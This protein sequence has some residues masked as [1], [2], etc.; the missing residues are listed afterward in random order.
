AVWA[1]SAAAHARKAAADAVLDAD[2]SAPAIEAATKA[3]AAASNATDIAVQAGHVKQAIESANQAIS[4]AYAAAED[5]ELAAIANED[6]A[7]FATEAGAEASEAV[8]QARLARA[9][10]VR[11]QRAAQAAER[12]LQVALA[13]TIAARDAALRAA[14]NAQAAAQAALHAAEHAGQAAE[15]ASLATEH[16]NAATV[17][18][19]AAVDAAAQAGT[20]FDAAR[21]ADAERLA[22]MRDEGLEGAQAANELYEAQQRQADFD[23]EQATKRDQQ[24][25]QLIAL[26]QN[27]ATPT[28]EAVAAARQV[29]L[30]LAQGQGVYT[31]QAAL[32]SLA[33]PDDQALEFVRTGLAAAEARDDRH[34][35]MNI[36][37]TDNAALAAAARTALAG[38]DAQVRTFL[39]TQNYPGRYTQDRVKVN[40]L[41]AAASAAGDVVLAQAA[42]AA[43]NAE[44]LQALREFLDTG[45]YTAAATGQRVRVNQ[46]AAAGG[47]EVKAAA[48]IALDGPPVLLAEFLGTGQYTAAERDYESMAH[49]STVGGM[50][51]NI[52]QIATTA[53]QNSQLAHSVAA[54]ARDD[55]QQA[56]AYAMQAAASAEQA[57]AYAIQ[58]QAYVAEA[59]QAVDKA[60]AA[61]A[62]ARS[63]ATRASTSARSAIRSAGWALLSHQAAVQSAI[64]AHDAA[65]FARA[66]AL[67]TG[68][69]A[70]DAAK[71]AFDAHISLRNVSI[72][73]CHHD[74]V[75]TPFD[76]L[77]ELWGQPD[78][79]FGRNCV[80]NNIPNPADP[81][82]FVKRIYGNAALCKVYPEGGQ[83]Y[84]NCVNST[85]DPAFGAMMPMTY[86]AEALKSLTATFATVG[87]TSAVLCVVTVVCATVAGTL[88]SLVEIGDNVIKLVNGDQTL[89]QT[90]LNL[91]QSALESLLLAGVGKLLSAGFRHLKDLYVASRNAN[92]LLVEIKLADLGRLHLVTAEW[93]K[94]C[95]RTGNSF[96]PDTPVLL[97]DGSSRPI[98]D[99]RIGDEVLATDPRSEVTRPRP[100]TDTIVG[101]GRKH[102]VEITVEGAG[103]ESGPSRITA[104]ANHPFWVPD[105]RQWVDAGNLRAGQLLRTGS[106]AW[107]QI[108]AVRS[109]TSQATVHNLTVAE[110]H[111]YYVV[112]GGTPVLVHNADGPPCITLAARDHVMKGVINGGGGF[113][114][115]HLHPNQSGGIP[116]DRFINGTLQVLSDGSVR[117]NGTVGARL[118]DGSIITKDATVGHTFFPEDWDENK[119]I[120]AG[121]YLFAHGRYTYPTK[122]TATY[123]GV[124]MTGFL[125]KQ[126]DGTYSPSTFFPSGGK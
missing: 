37:V 35:V 71:Q 64:D 59:T 62:T 4:A 97:A 18:A 12:Y 76:G 120:E 124:K 126:A 121:Q 111:T 9:N 10:A 67:A 14:A 24:T 2:K 117:V 3:S 92:K 107:V 56:A 118:P 95:V 22:V 52:H 38:T 77:E 65:E 101:T 50:L 40:Q 73:Q 48:Q 104:T 102:L 7:R 114:G 21:V 17:A 34:A 25:S 29:A 53:V 1:E 81:D 98:A 61:A 83:L 26:A 15:A 99:V 113:A 41:L 23:D 20:V 122:V 93:L 87:L 19:Q 49:L 13:A 96:A 43:L 32:D 11:A 72:T 105:L 88:F 79:S 91:G 55:A 6:A 58:A 119:I 46:I 85:A 66:V 44:T 57:T 60:A 45:R 84:R 123:D 30:A 31:R 74:Y 94:S 112:A 109:W 69:N 110:D 125:E 39:R 75:D 28:A 33:A 78:G 106:G 82:E 8:K 108:S 5:A 116:S 51:E 86:L 36:A 80:L 115:W 103:D 89:A 90:L 54:Q 27:P 42:Q 70:A 63:A 100:V 68:L 47:P 16:A